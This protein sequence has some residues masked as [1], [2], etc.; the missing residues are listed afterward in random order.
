MSEQSSSTVQT[1]TAADGAQ[2]Q[3][4]PHGGHICAWR[5]A[6][7]VQRLYLSPL[8]KL[9]GPGAIRGGVPVIFPQFAGDGLLPKHGFARELAWQALELPARADGQGA[10]AFELQDSPTTRAVFA[11]AFALRLETVFSG[12]ML[13]M[14]LTVHNT[15]EEPFAFTVALHTY[16]AVQSASAQLH[17]LENHAFANSA[18]AGRLTAA[19]RKPVQ[20]EGE[21]DRRYHAAPQPLTLRDARGAVRISQTGFADVVVWNPGQAVTSKIADLPED[22]FEHFVCVEAAA[23][24]RPVRLAPDGQWSGTQKFELL[25]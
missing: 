13:E 5:T 15:G 19:D 2:V 3:I 10:C 16:L 4:A 17:G 11:H 20:F 12:E 7:R 1:F 21:I 8:A 14:R 9:A 24:E 23:I 18:A 25:E 6:K 22:G